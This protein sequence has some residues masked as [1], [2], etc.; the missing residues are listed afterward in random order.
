MLLT[1]AVS[2][3]KSLQSSRRVSSFSTSSSE[4]WP[5]AV[6]AD[7]GGR[8][9]VSPRCFLVMCAS[10]PCT[11]FTCLRRELGSVYLFVQPGILQTYGF[12]KRIKIGHQHKHLVKK[13]NP[14]SSFLNTLYVKGFTIQIASK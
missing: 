5:P 8:G 4:F 9:P 6:T 12:C 11:V 3:A 13:I 14:C 7:P 1:R 2:G 10:G